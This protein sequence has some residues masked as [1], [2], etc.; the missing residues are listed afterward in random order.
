M[1]ALEFKYNFR[2]SLS[3]LFLVLINP[4]VSSQELED[5]IIQLEQVMSQRTEFDQLKENRINSLIKKKSSISSAYDS[6]K[7]NDKI[8]DEYEFYNFDNALGYIEK[9]LYLATQL[10]DI[11]LLDKARL[12]M[13]LLLVNTGRYKE[14]ID[15][16]SEIKKDSI[17]KI[18]LKNYFIAFSEGYSGLAFNTTVSESKSNYTQLYLVYRDSLYSR[19]DANSEEVLRAKEKDLRDI[20]SLKMAFIIN[21]KRLSKARKNSRRYSLITFE[22]SLLYELEGDVEN[23]KIN[24]ISSAISDIK[25]SVKDNASMATLAN[26]LFNEGDIDRAYS[27]INFSYGDAEFFNSNLRYINIANDMPLISKSYEQKTVKQKKRLQTLLF[28]ITILSFFLVLALYIIYKQVLKVSQARNELK[29]MNE[30][31]M[32]LNVKLSEVDRIKENYIGSFLNLYSEYI[33]KLDVYRKQVSKYVKNNQMNALLKLSESKQMI[34][35]ELEIF[36]KNFDNSFLHLHPDFVDSINKLLEDD[37]RVVVSESNKLN[38]ELRILALIKL[39]IT[40]SSKIA[41]ILRYSVNTIYNY[42]AALKNA[43]KDKSTFEDLVK[44]I[45]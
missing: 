11:L 1:K 17:P 37:K 33:S 4:S 30:D 27:L 35:E 3:A 21:D 31:L 38:T 29:L 40:S 36:N 41:K 28:Y 2:I 22:R 24:L 14:A 8:Y 23:Q 19:L 20:R 18:L 10:E 25:A 6:Y 44:K 26:I 34:D 13:G 5:Y 45:N 39:G 9:N 7:I 16:L 32:S 15:I 42:R 43:A 12:K